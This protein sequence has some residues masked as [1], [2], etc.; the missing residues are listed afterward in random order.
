[1]VHLNTS[2]V[3]HAFKK[4]CL[5]VYTVQGAQHTEKTVP[6]LKG[7][8]VKRRIKQTDK[9]NMVGEVLIMDARREVQGKPI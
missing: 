5:R 6:A 2:K 9:T 4:L 8:N 3:Y 7:L 1:M